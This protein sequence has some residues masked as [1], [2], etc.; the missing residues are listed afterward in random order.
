MIHCLARNLTAIRSVAQNKC[1]IRFVF[2]CFSE[3]SS[4]RDLVSTNLDVDNGVATVI[5][6]NAPVNS[7][8]MEM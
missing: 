8:S 6:D 4:G 5:M 2:R 7:L 1:N 3:D